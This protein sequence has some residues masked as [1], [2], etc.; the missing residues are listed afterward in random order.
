MM[1][2]NPLHCGQGA[3]WTVDPVISASVYVLCA[4]KDTVAY[5][6]PTALKWG[7]GVLFSC[8]N[9]LK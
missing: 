6:L 3:A 4:P 2:T 7:T 1:A 5:D 8:E 9:C